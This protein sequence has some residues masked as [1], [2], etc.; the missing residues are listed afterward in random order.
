VLSNGNMF[1]PLSSLTGFQ[2]MVLH[3]DSAPD[4]LAAL[5]PAAFGGRTGFH[6][7]QSAGVA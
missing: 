2:R 6:D 4:V 3:A 7:V 1:L 5:T